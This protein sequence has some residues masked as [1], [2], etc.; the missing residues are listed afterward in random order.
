MTNELNVTLK[1]IAELI[2]DKAKKENRP[3]GDVL[4]ELF[5]QL[6]EEQ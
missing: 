4:Q 5:Q 6:K 3:A 1:L 2:M